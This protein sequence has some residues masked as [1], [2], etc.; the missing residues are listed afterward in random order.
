M[1]KVI[2]LGIVLTMVMAFAV[3]AS[4]ADNK[5]TI[6]LRAGV[7]NGTTWSLAQNATT[8]GVQPTDV[9]D[10]FHASLASNA[11]GFYC[12]DPD[13][14]KMASK[15][16]RLF[17]PAAKSYTWNFKLATG[18]GWS[19]A[20]KATVGWYIPAATEAL[21]A[22]WTFD[23]FRNG[24]KVAGLVDNGQY[25]STKVA[26]AVTG[27]TLD[28]GAAEDWQLV[29]AVPE[30]GSIVAMLSGL[31]GLAGFGIRRRK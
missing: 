31:V 1:K 9:A 19:N 2:V 10:T 30:P 15:D 28:A 25:G 17:D 16:Y 29:A 26:A 5:W 7:L 22:G 8:V 3:G 6:C 27:I 13:A 21:A 4:A 24:V 11:A 12:V 20:N 23:L 14:A 18:S